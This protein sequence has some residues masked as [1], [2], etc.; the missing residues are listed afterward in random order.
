MN[1]RKVDDLIP[2]AVKELEKVGIAKNGSIDKTFRGQISTFGAAVVNGSLISAI[3]F[4]S[5]NGGS[6]V[7]RNKLLEAIKNLIPEAADKKD[8]F[9]YVQ[10]KGKAKEAEVKEKI[11]DAAIA[12]KLAMNL[13]KLV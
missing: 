10:K 1:K 3:A 7:D 2:A 5:D 4:F 9:D 12:L 8:L 11:I 13:Y 6:S